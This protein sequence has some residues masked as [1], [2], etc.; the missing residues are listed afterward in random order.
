MILFQVSLNFDPVKK[1]TQNMMSHLHFN[2]QNDYSESFAPPFSTMNETKHIHA[3][4][5]DLL[6]TVLE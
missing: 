3:S 2:E 4:D 6:H 1:N 5:A